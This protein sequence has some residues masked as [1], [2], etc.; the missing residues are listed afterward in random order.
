MHTTQGLAMRLQPTVCVPR[1]GWLC[2]VDSSE[3]GDNSQVK[4][5]HQIFLYQWRNT[6]KFHI[7]RL[8]V[9]LNECYLLNFPPWLRNA[10]ALPEKREIGLFENSGYC[11]THATNFCLSHDYFLLIWNYVPT[12]TVKR[13]SKK[14]LTAMSRG[15]TFERSR[16][17]SCFCK[18]CLFLL[19]HYLMSSISSGWF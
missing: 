15:A 2:P 17:K 8:L 9:Y 1:K 6:Y 16:C 11:W 4:S 10:M 14:P 19:R 7:G 3:E 13:P 5:R 18:S 12:N